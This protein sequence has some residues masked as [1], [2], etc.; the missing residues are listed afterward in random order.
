L[1][2]SGVQVEYDNV[3]LT[4]QSVA[5]APVPAGMKIDGTTGLITWTPDSDQVGTH[6]ISV[7]SDDGRGGTATQPFIIDVQPEPHNHTADRGTAPGTTASPSSGTYEY[8]VD[9]VDSDDD[10]LTDPPVSHP[11]DMTIDAAT[12]LISWVPSSTPVFN[13]GVTDLDTPLPV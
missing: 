11:S 7:M 12:G 13:S 9:A 3:R 5:I 2:S 4:S 10:T 8:D 1:L 6:P